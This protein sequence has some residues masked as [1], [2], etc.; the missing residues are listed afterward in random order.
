[1]KRVQGFKI[2]LMLCISLF[3]FSCGDVLTDMSENMGQEVT[4][5]VN[6]TSGDD[7]KDGRGWSNAVATL[8][9][10]VEIVKDGE[11]IWV[12]EGAYA[13]SASSAAIDK[14]ITIIGGFNGTES[15]TDE[16][17]GFSR[18]LLQSEGSDIFTINSCNVCIKNLNFERKSGAASSGLAVNISGNSVVKI[19]CCEFNDFYHLGGNAAAIQVSD[20][21]LELLSLTFS[22]NQA[23]YNGAALY[24]DNSTIVISGSVFSEN[25][26]LYGGNGSAVFASKSGLSIRSS[27]FIQNSAKNGSALYVTGEGDSGTVMEI[28]NT[29]FYDN[30]AT[31]VSSVYIT[32]SSD[33][34]TLNIVNCTFFSNTKGGIVVEYGG[35]ANL[36]NSIFFSTGKTYYRGSGT[37]N[38]KNNYWHTNDVPES[39]GGVV[40]DLGGNEISA[41]DPFASITYGDSN[42][43]YLVPGSLCVDSGTN[44]L[45]AIGMTLP[46]AD[47]AA[48][49][50]VVN[51]SVDM[52]CYEKQ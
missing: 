21:S 17:N 39:N 32:G 40:N 19:E 51:G 35:T 37:L 46:S 24:S 30:L 45:S 34:P 1:M 38:Y 20:S 48:N 16:L 10:A 9:R 36:Y 7:L 52:G 47:L 22:N 50:R 5:C 18:S 25:S 41:D 27:K 33:T 43:L 23:G 2:I 6:G 44:D 14:N 15:D 31:D 29:V 8:G 13:G 49:P 42:F 28:V 11:T 26:S 12:K 3:V 4:I